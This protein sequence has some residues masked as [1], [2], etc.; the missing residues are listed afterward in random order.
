M[1]LEKLLIDKTFYETFMSEHETNHPIQVLGEAYFNETELESENLSNIRF[2]QGE[3]Y[4][5]YKDYE[6][7][8]F[9][10]EKIKGELEPW[11]QKNIADSY[12]Q[13]GLLSKAEEIYTSVT[14]ES[15]ALTAEIALQLFSLYLEQERIDHAF[16]V[17]KEAVSLNPDYPNVTPLART[18]Y[19]E[20]NDWESA[21]E[22][23]VNEVIRTESP[24][25]IHILNSYINRGL[26]KTTN[27]D[28]FS[29]S[30][31]TVYKV[32]ETHFREMIVSHWN[33]YKNTELYLPWLQ[34]VNDLLVNIDLY[35]E[36]SW[37]EI[38]AL[39]RQTYLSL[40][41]GQYFIKEF[42]GLIPNHLTNWLKVANRDDAL[43]AS[44]AVLAWEGVFP[45]TVESLLLNNAEHLLYKYK[46]TENGLEGSLKLF[47]AVSAWA[48]K[49][50]FPIGYKLQWQME[51]LM[52]LQTNH[53]LVAGISGN[54]K[55]SFINSILGEQILGA[56]TS[57][58][59]I[60]NDGTHT[61]IKEITDEG[62]Q[63]LESLDAFY[64]ATAAG[65]ETKAAVEFKLPSRF[66]N[67]NAL[68]LIDTPGFTSQMEEKNE[69]FQYLHYADSL[70][71]VLNAHEPFTDRER[72]ILLDIQEYAPNLSIHFLLN[73]MDA[74][75][76][77]D[78]TNRIVEDVRA[79][80]RPYFP[81]AIVFPYSSAYT[82]SQLLSELA[83]F[84]QSTFGNR[85][86]AE[87]RTSQVLST[88]RNLLVYV[89]E[90]RIEVEN[91]LI[92]SIQWNE[93]ILVKLNGLINNV[94]A[95]ETE[96]IN[97][98]T[99]SYRNIKEEITK[100]FTKELPKLLKSCSGIL[101]TDND[102]RNIH[103]ELNEEMN[104]RIQDYV[105]ANA[106]PKFTTFILDWIANIKEEFVQSQNYLD[107]MSE[108]FNILYNEDKMKLECDFRVL[109]DWRR[110][111]DRMIRRVRI[112]DMNILTRF[113]PAQFLLKSAGKL[114]G[115]L[116]QNK[117]MLYNQYTKYV[118]NE[119]Y[120]DAINSVIHMFFEQFVLFEKSL[121]EDI[122][123]FFRDPFGMLKQMV[124]E[125]HLEI[126]ENRDG[127][128]EMRANPE[129][130]QDPL[131]LFHL[132]LRQQE[133][134][135]NMRNVSQYVPT[136]TEV[137]PI[138]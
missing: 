105:T 11:A 21:I 39:Y 49:N 128:S 68:T 71:F 114:F 124:E 19:E 83:L 57:N 92:D 6:A 79:R 12:F 121:D 86:L 50:E 17:I 37:D 20:Q 62:V 40:I 7:A 107:E 27:P 81:D 63:H 99:A 106:L 115:G 78:E 89:M 96:K 36:T 60:F 130:F 93:D 34:A 87:Q 9:K 54:G 77:E 47:E 76:R 126:Q 112:D 10:W 136:E 134:I 127:L 125:T 137:E 25:W 94:T 1:T 33:S 97:T 46:G 64:D 56:S 131:K 41:N 13:L 74:I 123:L 95:L 66:L 122:N 52:D 3:M 23:A 110:D 118:E 80:I 67:K 26:T 2:G 22:L 135:W 18:F 42:Q 15:A 51:Q 30:L 8:I 72:N 129:V 65:Y 138:G 100:D 35:T 58:V 119:D 31:A 108:T 69:T 85:D 111:I 133:V 44:A 132:R 43:F 38:S 55:S 59:V 103:T 45:A 113:T 109:D 4:Y 24:S 48:Y 53:L 28:Y 75:H 82:S 117:N 5:R 84:I 120:T 98:I 104:N 90:K 116:Q 91:S 101:D 14:T 70:L 88:V 29:Q 61:E 16:R 73:K 102:F 32:D